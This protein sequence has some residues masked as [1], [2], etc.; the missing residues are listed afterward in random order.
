MVKNRKEVKGFFAC[1]PE[2]ANFSLAFFRRVYYTI[3][4]HLPA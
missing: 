4:T 1:G 3:R 2:D